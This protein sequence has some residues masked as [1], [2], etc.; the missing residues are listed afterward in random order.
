MVI[1]VETRTFEI[2]ELEQR[3]VSEGI[4]IVG[5]ELSSTN[6]PDDE[7]EKWYF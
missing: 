6:P 7:V 1:I 2:F 3:P 5:F 4:K